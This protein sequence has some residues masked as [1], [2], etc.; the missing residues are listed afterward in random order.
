M[1]TFVPQEH[2]W[3]IRIESVS[4]FWQHSTSKWKRYS[5]HTYPVFFSLFS[6]WSRTSSLR[7]SESLFPPHNQIQPINK[8]FFMFTKD[9]SMTFR[10]HHTVFMHSSSYILWPEIHSFSPFDLVFCNFES[11]FNFIDVT[12]FILYPGYFFFLY[13]L[14][15]FYLFKT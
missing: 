6:S 14:I 9:F 15:S 8:F 11:L 5:Y 3:K 1:G 4:I 10:I 7:H 13:I 2:R 12:C